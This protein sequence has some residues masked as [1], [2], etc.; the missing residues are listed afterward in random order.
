MMAKRG[1]PRG[2]KYGAV[3]DVLLAMADE[4]LRSGQPLRLTAEVR[5]LVA[6]LA[7]LRGRPLSDKVDAKLLAL[8]NGIFRSQYLLDA[9]RLPTSWTPWSAISYVVQCVCQVPG[10]QA[11]LGNS[12]NAIRYRL[13]ARLHPLVISLGKR[14]YRS[15]ISSYAH[16]KIARELM[17]AQQLA[18]LDLGQTP[19]T[20]RAEPTILGRGVRG[21][22]PR[23]PGT[24]TAIEK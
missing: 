23:A 14:N 5:V 10:L 4:V 17:N 24:P 20:R 1:R 11:E 12:R 13:Y 9:V 15:R 7:F 18:Y 16:L 3:D 22:P 6:R 19:G 8:A 2:D 21:R